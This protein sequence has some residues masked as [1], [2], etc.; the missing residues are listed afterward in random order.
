MADIEDPTNPQ[1][2]AVY[3]MEN[4]H[5]LSV[6]DNHL[7]L[8]EGDFGL[9]SFNISDKNKIDKNL[10]QHLK[11]IKSFDVIAGPKSLIVIGEDGVYQFNYS[12]PSAL[13]KLSKIAVE[14]SISHELW[15]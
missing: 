15:Y 7:F 2:G 3:P 5:G 14:T 8:C 12:K 6:S 13:R 11:G 1:Q 9:K 10:L 4:P